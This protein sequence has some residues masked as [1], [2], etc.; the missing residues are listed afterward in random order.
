MIE[1]RYFGDGVQQYRKRAIVSDQKVEISHLHREPSRLRG[2]DPV[3][4]PGLDSG[5]EKVRN[6]AAFATFTQSQNLVW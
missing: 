5:A 6:D 4:E 2:P 3:P 1:I